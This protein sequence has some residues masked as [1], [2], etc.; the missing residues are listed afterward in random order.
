MKRLLLSVVIL[1]LFA[2]PAWAQT[3]KAL[4]IVPDDALG[5]ILIK[6]LRQLYDKGEDLAAKTNGKAQ[7]AFV[8]GLLSKDLR[9]GLNEKGSVVV[10]VMSGKDEKT[11]PC[12]ILALPVGDN[13]VLMQILGVKE[14]AK[15]GISMGTIDAPLLTRFWFESKEKAK[16]GKEPLGP[17]MPVLVAK[18]DGFVLLTAVES[19]DQLQRIL[20]AKKSIASIVEPAK[21]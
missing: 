5:F 19:K 15:D 6:D 16:D 18:R 12:P 7:F 21:T 17:K 4:E 11:F 14:E 10:I 3:N 2:L 1:G 9:K 20:S 8:D 13:A